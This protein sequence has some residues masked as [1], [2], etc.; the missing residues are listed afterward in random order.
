M[1]L[2]TSFLCPPAT[3]FVY[4]IE[5]GNNETPAA[6]EAE[7]C[8]ADCKAKLGDLMNSVDPEAPRT[9]KKSM[10]KVAGFGVDDFPR[11]TESFYPSGDGSGGDGHDTGDKYGS[12]MERGPN[13]ERIWVNNN[14]SFNSGL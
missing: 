6:A 2:L 12:H 3:R 5:A 14:D 11:S 13:G 10:P 9:R 8:K 1:K 4:D 7:A